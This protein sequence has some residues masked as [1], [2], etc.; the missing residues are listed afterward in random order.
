MKGWMYHEQAEIF[1]QRHVWS[2]RSYRGQGAGGKQSPNLQ[3]AA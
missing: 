2:Y 1:S 3:P